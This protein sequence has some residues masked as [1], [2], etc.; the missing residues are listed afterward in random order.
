MR[1]RRRGESVAAYVRARGQ[2]PGTAGK[3]PARAPFHDAGDGARVCTG[4]PRGERGAREGAPTT[5]RLLPGT[6]GG[7]RAGVAGT[8]AESVVGPAGDRARQSTCR[9]GVEPLFPGRHRIGD[10]VDWRSVAFLVCP[11]SPQ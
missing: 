1:Y 7:G 6:G 10:A 5:L 3:H 8:A 4:T 9:S 2:E 11:R